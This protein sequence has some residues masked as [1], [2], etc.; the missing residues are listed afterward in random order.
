MDKRREIT[1]QL[2]SMLAGRKGGGSFLLSFVPELKISGKD[3][4]AEALRRNY[5]REL[6]SLRPQDGPGYDDLVITLADSGRL[7]QEALSRGQ[8]RRV[9]LELLT[10][11]GRLIAHRMK[12]KPVMLFDDLTAE[13]DAEGREFVYKELVKTKWQVFMTA[14]EKPF[15]VRKK[16]RGINLA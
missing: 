7:A 10:A 12:R 16:F 13:L 11:S 3:Y 6:R 14:P 8:K 1:S 9:I 15:A 2:M 5:A 4:L